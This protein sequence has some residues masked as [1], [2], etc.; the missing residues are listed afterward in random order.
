[1]G[2]KKK[3]VKKTTKNL[4]KKF[5]SEMYVSS[6]NYS[7]SYKGLGYSTVA[8][9]CVSRKKVGKVFVDKPRTINDGG[10]VI[11]VQSEGPG[12]DSFNTSLE[13][14]RK[15]L[16]ALVASLQKFLTGRQSQ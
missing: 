15:D 8:V 7:E 13:L 2:K 4:R 10:A 6:S 16:V 14:S 1:M 12:D 9:A 11:Q 5:A 3:V